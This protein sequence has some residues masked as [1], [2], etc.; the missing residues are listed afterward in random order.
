MS[1]TLV[2]LA[3]LV[4]LIACANV[5]G[6]LLARAEYRRQE[7]AMR[8]VLKKKCVLWFFL[9]LVELRADRGRRDA[10]GALAV[11]SYVIDWA[12]GNSARHRLH[13]ADRCPHERAGSPFAGSAA[14]W[15][16]SYLCPPGRPNRADDARAWVA[17]T[18][19]RGHPS[20]GALWAIRGRGRVFLVLM[21]SGGL[22]VRGCSSTRR[23]PTPASTRT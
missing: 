23:A 10:G 21:V 18:F 22:L 6:L 19:R 3:A 16:R 7:L 20:A 5:A 1:R 8:V 11:G 17:G 15:I 2:G 13:F 14:S 12:A 4:L 9:L